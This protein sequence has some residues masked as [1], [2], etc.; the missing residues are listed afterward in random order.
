MTE[1]AAPDSPPTERGTNRGK[2]G[3]PTI[4]KMAE[5]IA[6][7]LRA[8]IL[9]GELKPG[10]SLLSEA[11]L[12][13]EYDVSRPTLREALRL[14][15]A[16]ELVTVRRGSHRGPVVSLPDIS[17]A[18]RSVAIQLQ[19]RRATLADVYRFRMIFE[20]PAV[21]MAAESA[22]Q[23]DIQALRAVLEE[24]DVRRGD[25]SA[26]AAVSWRFHTVL[27]NLSANPAMAVIAE[28][29]QRISERHAAQSLAAADDRDKQ[30]KRALRAHRKLVDLIEAGAGAEAEQFWR[31][32]MAAVAKVVLEKAEGYV[33]TELTD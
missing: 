3:T 4:P 17:V 33:I 32:H 26:F 31:T 29:L 21:R 28:S 10:E 12:V 1:A 14:L 7:E 30:Q 9:S 24:E 27:I 18:A 22:T 15:E 25:F 13:E 6:A 5:L 16:Q 8:K 11:S 2:R 20:P 23:Q 19:L